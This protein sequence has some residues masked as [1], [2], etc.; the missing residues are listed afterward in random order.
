MNRRLFSVHTIALAIAGLVAAV[1]TNALAQAPAAYPTKPIKMIIPF[2]P[3]GTTDLVGRIVA[4]KLSAALGQTV[5]V[6][7]RGG[8][9]GAI[10]ALELVKAAPDGYTIGISTVSTMA[11]NPAANPNTKYNPLTDFIAVTNLAAVPNVLVTNPKALPAKDMKELVAAAKA[12]PGKIN[13]GSSGTAGIGHM[14]GE[15][16]QASSGTDL[17]HVPY[18]GAGPAL[19]DL[20]G[21]QIPMMFDNLPSSL[22]HIKSGNLKAMAVAAP[23]RL[24]IL[25]DVPTFAELNMKDVNDQA[26]YGIVLPAKTPDAVVKRLHEAAVKVLAMPDVKEKLAAQG[27]AAVGNSPT[28][29][30]AQIKAEFEKMKAIVTKKGIKLD[31]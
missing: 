10:G 28:E 23:K 14:M 27:A 1:G 25:P 29:Y 13:F 20:L 4:D 31:S 21:G 9:G 12:A 19:T 22:Q 7:N 5:V 6:E 26:W 8:G 15:L 30:S 18:K 3:G 17:T 2:P 11:V 16:F 24:E